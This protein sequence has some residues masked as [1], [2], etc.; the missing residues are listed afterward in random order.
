[1]V[2]IGLGKAG[3][4]IAEMFKSY[5]N[6]KVLTYD[7]GKNVPL[8]ESS[9]GYEMDSQTKKNLKKLKKKLSGFLFVVQEKL[10]G[11]LYDYLNKSK[12]TK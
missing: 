10:L 11:R 6:Y 9:E 3:C 7:G 4:N 2:V 1:M 8:N 12:K 5:D